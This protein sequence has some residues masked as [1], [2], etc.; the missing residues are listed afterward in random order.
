MQADADKT[1]APAGPMPTLFEAI[2]R[3]RCVNASY[4]RAPVLLAPHVLYT[5]HGVP[6]VD[7]VTLLRDGQR[8]REEKL[9]AFKVDGLGE[10]TLDEREFFPNITLY[11]PGSERYAGVTLLGV[12]LD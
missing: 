5:K 6:Y 8:P 7:A 12:E 4:N 2:V 3:R 11:S 1:A 9:G 10:I